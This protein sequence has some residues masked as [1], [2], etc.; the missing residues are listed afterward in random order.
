MYGAGLTGGNADQV[1]YGCAPVIA[2]AAAQK[3]LLPVG[4]GPLGPD[5]PDLLEQLSAMPAV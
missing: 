2:L 5:V 3:S 1:L 4:D